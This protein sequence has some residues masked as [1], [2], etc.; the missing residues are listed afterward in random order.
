[1]NKNKSEKTVTGNLFTFISVLLTTFLLASFME[2]AVAQEEPASPEG[3]AEQFDGLVPVQDSVVAT[4]YVNPDAD[5][6]VF[7]RVMI[8]EPFV[9]FRSN[10]QRDQQRSRNRISASDMERIKAD[11]ARIFREVF[12]ERLEANDGYTVVDTADYDVLLLRP[13]IID[14]D[15]TAPDTMSTGRSRTATASAGAAT[16]YLELFDSVS[17]EILARVADRRTV[18]SGSGRMTV[19]NRVT[20]RQE[21]RRMFGRW[22]DILRDRLDE[23][24]PSKDTPPADSE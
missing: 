7:E 14:L 17:G 3:A 11:V 12:T 6:G 22:A 23:F 13:A 1:M 2:P 19:S 15:I 10:W 5:F 16:L 18:R 4:A 8:L 24:Y 9:A 21:A 20:N